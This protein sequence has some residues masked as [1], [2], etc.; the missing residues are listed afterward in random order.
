M[1][2]RP[3][4]TPGRFTVQFADPLQADSYYSVYD[5]MGRLLYQRP[6]PKGMASE[7]IDLSR[8]GSGTYVLKL[9]TTEGVCT[10]RVLVS[11]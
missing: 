2:L 7:E 6:W 11:P 8:F 4:P 5:T 9:T 10:E 1:Q 3:N